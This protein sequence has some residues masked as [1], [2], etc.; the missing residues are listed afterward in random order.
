VSILSDAWNRRYTQWLEYTLAVVRVVDSGTAVPLGPSLPP[1]MPPAFPEGTPGPK[2]VFC[3]PHPDD[4]SLSGA[5][6]LRLRLQGAEVTDVAITLGSDVTERQRRSAEL[7][8][9][10]RVLGFKLAVPVASS[11]R[12]GFDD[13]NTESRQAR[14]R[15]WA[16]KVQAL[17]DIF[18]HEKPD[19]VFAPHAR[20]F[21]TTHIGTH[22]L[23][24]DAMSIHL[25]HAGRDILP[26]IQTEFWHQL[27]SPNLM[28]GLSPE[29][30]AHQMTAIAEH[31]GEMS[32]NPYHLRHSCRLMDNVR[33]GSEVVEG[34]GSPA[35]QFTFAELYQVSFVKE[36]EVLAPRAGTRLIGPQNPIDIESLT[37]EFRRRL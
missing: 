35:Q 21:N 12:S 7:E 22:F 30:V 19:V 13:V 29:L 26:M 31:G 6:A 33:R 36:G 3:A 11:G 15:E 28:V 9:A 37:A 2:V 34:Q 23:V 4:E 14:P 17:T 18:D 27:D 24:V 10:C 25:K 1:L 5:L 20:D 8:A 16:A 32:R